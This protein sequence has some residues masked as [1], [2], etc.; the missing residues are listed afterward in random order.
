M[1]VLSSCNVHIFY[2]SDT[3]IFFAREILVLFHVSV[4]ELVPKRP[5]GAAGVR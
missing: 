1:N 5:E 2:N 3:N 4:L